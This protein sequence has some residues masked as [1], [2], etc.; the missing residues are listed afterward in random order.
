M[1]KKK[2]WAKNAQS[3]TNMQKDCFSIS[4]VQTVSK[5]T[6][7]ALKIIHNVVHIA[8]QCLVVVCL[9]LLLQMIPIRDSLLVVLMCLSGFCGF[10]VCAIFNKWRWL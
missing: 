10:A 8:V 6:Y 1:T 4:R 5:K 7:S 3:I 2:Q 9:L